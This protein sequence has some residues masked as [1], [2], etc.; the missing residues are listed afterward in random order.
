MR[1]RVEKKARS[2]AP[3]ASALTP[4]RAPALPLPTGG[5]LSELVLRQSGRLSRSVVLLQGAKSRE[6]ATRTGLSYFTCGHMG[7]TMSQYLDMA[8]ACDVINAHFQALC[9]SQRNWGQR[10][11]AGWAAEQR[12][13]AFLPPVCKQMGE[14]EAWMGKEQFALMSGDAQ[15]PAWLQQAAAGGEDAPALKCIASLE[16]LLKGCSRFV[17]ARMDLLK[18]TAGPPESWPAAIHVM[19]LEGKAAIVES[20]AFTSAASALLSQL[21][22][23]GSLEGYE[24]ACD[25]VLAAGCRYTQDVAETYRRRVSWAQEMMA[26]GVAP[27]PATHFGTREHITVFMNV[28]AV[29]K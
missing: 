17:A 15:P 3:D 20:F 18:E 14:A 11:R 19:A 23:E 4:T 8:R 5:A 16:A 25:A 9:L 10:V 2:D 13:L 1:R 21:R 29:V 26:Q 22:A 7:D 12:S 28:E 6:A 24:A 27:L